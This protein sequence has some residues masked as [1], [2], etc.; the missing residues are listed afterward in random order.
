MVLR[1]QGQASAPS[2]CKNTALPIAKVLY[3]AKQPGKDRVI[4]EVSYQAKNKS[5][6]QG[7]ADITVMPAS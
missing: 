1:S 5:T 3:R 4:W 7:T 2:P 6:E